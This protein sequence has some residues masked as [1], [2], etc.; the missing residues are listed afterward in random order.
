MK[1]SNAT[2]RKNLIVIGWNIGMYHCRKWKQSGG[3][4]FDNGIFD[5][6]RALYGVFVRNQLL[7]NDRL[8][9]LFDKFDR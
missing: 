7:L 4:S 5:I 6:G 9:A 8:A 2:D 3:D 1:F